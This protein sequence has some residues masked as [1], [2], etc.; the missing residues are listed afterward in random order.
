MTQDNIP[1]PE[2][3]GVSTGKKVLVVV[4]ALVAVGTLALHL[5]LRQGEEGT[6]LR[7]MYTSATV[8]H[9]EPATKTET[10]FGGFARR[11]T[12]F[13]RSMTPGT[14][15]VDVGDFLLSGNP[16]SYVYREARS[17]FVMAAMA[18]S[19][20]EVVNIGFG[21]QTFGRSYLEKAAGQ[22]GL[23][24]ISASLVD[25]E[26]N[27]YAF[28]P[29]VVLE[30]E[31]I[32]IAFVGVIDDERLFKLE[33]TKAMAI[34]AAETEESRAFYRSIITEGEGFK[35]LGLTQALVR[36]KPLVEG[37]ADVV[38]LMGD[39]DVNIW[40]E[41]SPYRDGSLFDLALATSEDS[42]DEPEMNGQVPVFY[43]G[44]HGRE[45]GVLDLVVTE[46]GKTKVAAW[47]SE[48]LTSDI[49]DD[50]DMLALIADQRRSLKDI[51]PLVLTKK[52]PPPGEAVYAGSEKCAHCHGQAFRI[53][54]QTAHA[55]AL[56]SLKPKGA[57]YDPGCVVCHVTD[58]PSQDGYVDEETTP[59]MANVSCESCHDRA[60]IHV[61]ARMNRTQLEGMKAFVPAPPVCIRCH[62][63]A[64]S[65]DFDYRTYWAKIQHGHG[66]TPEG[67]EEP[68][69][70][71]DG[72]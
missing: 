35:I 55:H 43:N 67:F 41:L 4:I 10:V 7:L 5:W 19:G 42:M 48:P 57:E 53:W 68:G 51:D 17:R 66:R 52:R 72:H 12:F 8:G 70:Q 27:E 61:E 6:P 56:E 54:Q 71:A 59:G 69:G 3:T 37:K 11:A 24:F 50:E 60:S 22:Y 64:N 63:K 29:F 9:L 34:A 25:P 45:V 33:E 47:R 18:E 65:P 38:V 16:P 44:R 14:T 20:V 32:R 31:G 21:D 39:G 30:K 1:E 46:S 15:I 28:D 13:K 40:N 23:T 62:D 36:I 49:P 26:T 2:N 58:H